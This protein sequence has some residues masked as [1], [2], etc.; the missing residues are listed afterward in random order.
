[1]PADVLGVR[2]ARKTL[3]AVAGLVS[4]RDRTWTTDRA[5]AARRWGEIKPGLAAPLRKLLSWATAG[6]RP[7]PQ[8]VPPALAGDGIVAAVAERFA[9]LIGL[10]ADDQQDP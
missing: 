2:A 7:A 3:L 4:V 6:R 10:W 8:E 1:V 5:R 9:D